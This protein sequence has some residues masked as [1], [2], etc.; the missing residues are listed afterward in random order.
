MDLLAVHQTSSRIRDEC[1]DLLNH[2]WP[3]S[4]ALRMRTID[5]SRDS[6]PA[7]FALVAQGGDGVVL[8]TLKMSPIPSDPKAVWIE[9]VVVHPG[10]RGKG[11]GKYLM[12]TAEK[13]ARE[14]MGYEKA[15]L[16]TFDQQIFYSKLG[17]SFC[18]PICSYGGNIALKGNLAEG[19]RR[20][21]QDNSAPKTDK[22]NHVQPKPTPPFP[23]SGAVPPAP[24]PPPPPPLAPPPPPTPAGPLPSSSNSGSPSEDISLQ[25]AKVFSRPSL[26]SQP[27]RLE[28]MPRR[29]SPSRDIVKTNKDSICRA[30]LSKDFMCKRL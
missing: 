4:R 20:Q 11:V 27:P 3:R 23:D 1:C 13:K 9:S 5:S 18:A 12:L 30:V 26:P 14:E 2:E 19:I 10:C 24:P 17:Y 8:G 21:G 28:K 22:T 25:C 7:V 29:L 15:Y 6:L 16:S